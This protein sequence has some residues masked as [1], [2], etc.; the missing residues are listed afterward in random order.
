ME[1]HSHL[2]V[3][4]ARYESKRRKEMQEHFG[5][6]SKKSRQHSVLPMC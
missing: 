4:L 2:E 6:W 3:S 1:I 5:G